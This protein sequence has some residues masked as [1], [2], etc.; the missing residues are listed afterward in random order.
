LK[1]DELIKGC[2]KQDRKSQEALYHL[3]KERLFVLCLKYCRNEAEAED[4]LHNAF[5]EI[6]TNIHSF[7][8]KGT[9]EG[10]V[11]RI[12]INI[13]V[14]SYKKTAHLSPIYDDTVQDTSV[15]YEDMALPLDKILALVQD[16]PNQYRLVFSLYALD[17]FSHREI[18]D[19]LGISE[20][21]SKSNL[22]RAKVILKEKIQH[23]KNRIHNNASNGH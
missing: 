17:D 10:W 15:D 5:V 23:C 18:A 19:M 21:T 8:G 7:E 1:P 16:L 3:Y 20:S 4:S 6:F 11:K 2:L 12:A 22:H 9:F 13:A 14:N